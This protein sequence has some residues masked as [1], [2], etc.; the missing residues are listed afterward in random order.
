MPQ[1]EDCVLLAVDR[2]I[3]R[4]TFNRP[5]QLNAISLAMHRRLNEILDDLQQR[6]DIRVM[7]LTGNGRAFCAGQ[8]LSERN[9]ER[10]G[11]LDLGES[12]EARYN[13]LVRRL[14]SL[15]FPFVSA[16]NGVAAGAGANIA[17]LADIVIAR[18][19]ARFIQSFAKIGLMPDCGG[20]WT[21]PHLVGQPR[22]LAIAMT[23]EPVNGRDAANWGMIWKAVPDDA[24]DDAVEALVRDVAAAP[25]KGLMET[26]DAIRGAWT[27]S[28]AEQLVVERDGQR[29]LGRTRDYREGVSAFKDRRTAKFQGH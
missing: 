18:E 1:D 27:R 15:P 4:V 7:L 6:D 25:T 21:L 5:E 16:V 10:D 3:A 23:G 17:L 14:V 24:F 11:P 26:R 13:P 19:S 22:A 9:V 8:D 28:F 12:L 29:R 20:S 2:G